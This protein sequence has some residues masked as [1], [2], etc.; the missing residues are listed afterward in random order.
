MPQFLRS[1]GVL[2]RQADRICQYKVAVR[3]MLVVIN[4]FF[5]YENKPPFKGGAL[6]M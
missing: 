2:L 1:V 4:I 3:V 6:P 5:G